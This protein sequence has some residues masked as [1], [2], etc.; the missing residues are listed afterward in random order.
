MKDLTSLK[1]HIALK[2]NQVNLN[3]LSAVST[4]LEPN[5]VRVFRNLIKTNAHGNAQ[6][7]EFFFSNIEKFADLAVRRFERKSSLRSRA[8]ILKQ[9]QLSNQF[10]NQVDSVAAGNLID[11]LLSNLSLYDHQALLMKAR[12]SRKGGRGS[13]KANPNYFDEQRANEFEFQV[14]PACDLDVL[15]TEILKYHSSYNQQCQST[16][17]LLYIAEVIELYQDIY[18]ELRSASSQK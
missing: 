14:P 7:N 6:Q 15:P 10:S 2:R 8:T 5:L 4:C 9:C 18:C 3:I 16:K 11:G 1:C 13:P 17:L 12:G